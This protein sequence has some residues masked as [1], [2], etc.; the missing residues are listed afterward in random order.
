MDS[1]VLTSLIVFVIILFASN[2]V[3]LASIMAAIALPIAIFSAESIRGVEHDINLL[4]FAIILAM[5]LIAAHRLNISRLASGTG[6][7]FL[8]HEK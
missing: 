2:Y 4:V 7:R 3:S 5:A 6:N 1:S 8:S